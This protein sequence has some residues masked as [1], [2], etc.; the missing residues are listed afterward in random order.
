VVIFATFKYVNVKSTMFPHR[1]M[2]NI[3]WPSP[4]GETH[5]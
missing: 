4:D 1:N 2:H 3:T 5:N